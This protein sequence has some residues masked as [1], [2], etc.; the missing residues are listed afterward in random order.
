MSAKMF[1]LLVIAMVA[2][3]VVMG[4]M[5]LRLLA[6]DDGTE[7]AAILVEF[8]ETGSPIPEEEQPSVG[9]VE[10]TRSDQGIDARVTMRD[11]V[12]GGVYTFWFVVPQGDRVF[13]GDVFVNEGRGVVADETGTV[14]VTMRSEKGDEPITGYFVEDM[15]DIVFDS[16]HDPMTA[17]VR[18]EVIY[19][20]QAAQ[21]GDSLDNWLADFWTGDPTVCANPLGSLGTGNVPTHPYCP[22]HW[23]ATFAVDGDAGLPD[24]PTRA[25][26]TADDGS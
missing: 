18:V 23:A 4:G 2:A 13:P 8:D 21:A 7:H 12:P 6:S 10:L 26:T 15:G 11:L 25:P 16:L 9:D 5:L 14:E 1:R 3:A 20:G 17:L 22:G 24:A 19:H